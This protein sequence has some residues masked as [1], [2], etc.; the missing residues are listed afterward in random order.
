[1]ARRTSVLYEKR[2]GTT[3][4]TSAVIFKQKQKWTLSPTWKMEF[5]L[6][7]GGERERGRERGRGER[8]ICCSI[9]RNLNVIQY[10]DDLREQVFLGMRNLTFSHISTLD[11]DTYEGQSGGGGGGGRGGWGEQE[12]R[13]ETGGR[14]R[15]TRLSPLFLSP[16]TCLS[17]LLPLSLFSHG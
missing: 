7:E 1:M 3:E 9:F 10:A 16:P 8:E 2:S 15:G 6:S 4:L 11:C 17:S 13:R 12:G 14:G 5:G